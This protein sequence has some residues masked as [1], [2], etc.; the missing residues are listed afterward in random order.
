MACVSPSHRSLDPVAYFQCHKHPKIVS[1]ILLSLPKV[2]DLQACML[3]SKRWEEASPR[4]VLIK[5]IES[6]RFDVVRNLLEQGLSPKF[7]IA[8]TKF[9]PGAEN[10]PY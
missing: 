2:S 4:K 1:K 8:G 3:V 5:A 7:R 6:N 10:T 9:V